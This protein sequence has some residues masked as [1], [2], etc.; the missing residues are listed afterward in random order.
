MLIQKPIIDDLLNV[1][2]FHQ[3]KPFWKAFCY[4]IRKE[5]VYHSGASEYEIYFNFALSKTYQ[6][7]VR[8]LL[9]DNVLSLDEIEKYRDKGYHYIS[10][11][12]Y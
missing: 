3:Q 10:C 9:W 12:S 7:K 1:V 8:K 5:D 6:V 2:E 4:L 11:H